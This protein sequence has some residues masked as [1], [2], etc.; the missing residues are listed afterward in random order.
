[1]KRLH[2]AI[3]TKLHENCQNACFDKLHENCQNTCLDKSEACLAELRFLEICKARS[4]IP[5]RAV[6]RKEPF[7]AIKISEETVQL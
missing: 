1:M 2:F 6:L 5:E 4:V 3:F 7:R